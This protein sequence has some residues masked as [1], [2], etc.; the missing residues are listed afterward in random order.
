MSKKKIEA[1]ELELLDAEISKVLNEASTLEASNSEGTLFFRHRLNREMIS[2]LSNIGFSC[3]DYIAWRANFSEWLTK[4]SINFPILY[5]SI[6]DDFYSEEITDK[7]LIESK[8]FYAIYR[9]L[10][11]SMPDKLRI[12]IIAG[13]IL[14]FKATGNNEL[15]ENI[16]NSI[17]K[18]WT[19]Y[20]LQGT[21]CP[22]EIALVA[23]LISDN[24]ITIASLHKKRGAKPKPEKIT[25]MIVFATFYEVYKRLNKSNRGVIVYIQNEIKKIN[26]LN[27]ASFKEYNTENS[28]SYGWI[29]KFNH[30][31]ETDLSSIW[32][33]FPSTTLF[34]IYNY[35]ESPSM[36]V[37]NSND[38]S[39]FNNHELGREIR[40][41]LKTPHRAFILNI[42]D[43][44]LM[45]NSQ[46]G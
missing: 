36:M 30:I 21:S 11:L 28:E 3:D 46:G 12:R 42:V 31:N 23:A 2:Q 9:L 35:I 25:A 40:S 6:S 38:K 17:T 34:T 5:Q 39:I 10:L 26:A 15:P 13:L 4:I 1:T 14:I 33:I 41:I 8:S 24:Q 45:I 18:S 27:K 43:S 44:Y 29:D 20:T 16:A 19:Q 7:T 37:E 22:R 32:N